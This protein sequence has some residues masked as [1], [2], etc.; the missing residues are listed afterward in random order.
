MK[1]T[2]NANEKKNK[3][4]KIKRISIVDQISD[5]IKQGII[6]GVWKPGDKL[7][8][9]SEFAKMYGV[10]RLSVRMALQ[11]LST[12]GILETR[13]GEG[14]FVNNFSMYPIFKEIAVFYKGEN[15]ERDLKQFRN[16]LESECL[17]IAVESPSEEEV[18]ELRNRLDAYNKQLIIYSQNLD[19]EAELDKLVDCDFDFHYQVILMSHNVLYKEMY[20]LVKVLVREHIKQLISKRL[21]HRKEK[22][23][24]LIN[25]NDTHNRIYEAIK[26][27][28][29]SA[30]KELTYEMLNV[31]PAKDFM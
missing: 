3:I 20:E 8:S 18:N 1:Q 25:P 6:D 16:L 30:V 7:P 5:E 22:N 27:S 2:M 15:I 28:D 13:V 4:K 12:L 19:D 14:S 21:R 11:K 17:R 29:K 10:N 9:E 23:L 26:N 31:V 24:P